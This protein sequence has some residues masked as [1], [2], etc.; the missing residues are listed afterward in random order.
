MP[1]TTPPEVDV[2]DPLDV[3]VLADLDVPP[4]ERDAGIVVDLVDLAEVRLDAVGVG[5]EGLP[6][7]DVQPIGLDVHTDRLEALL[8]DRETLGVDIA[9]GQLGT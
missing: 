3:L 9:D 2:H 8:G 1:L 5:L 7:G 4:G 6:L